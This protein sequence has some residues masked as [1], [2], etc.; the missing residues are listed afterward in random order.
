MARKKKNQNKKKRK[1]GV[2]APQKSKKR[3]TTNAQSQPQFGA[4]VA[5]SRRVVTRAPDISRSKNGE[6]TRV[7][8]SELID[9][10]AG[11]ILFS[12]LPYAL[13]PNSFPWLSAMAVDW[14]QYRFHSVTMRY[15]TR[16]PTSATG[17]V[18]MAC[19]YDPGEALPLEEKTL[20]AYAG[21]VSDVTWSDL[22][23]TLDV[24]AMFPTGPRK[25]IRNAASF[26]PYQDDRLTYAGTVVVGTVGQADGSAIGKLWVDYDVELFVPQS[27]SAL[28]APSNSGNTAIFSRVAN[29][30]LLQGVETTYDFDQGLVDL[31]PNLLSSIPVVLEAGGVLQFNQVGVF[32]AHV[33]TILRIS[34]GETLSWAVLLQVA[35]LGGVYVPLPFGGSTLCREEIDV[36]DGEMQLSATGL[37]EVQSIGTTF[38][39]RF[40]ASTVQGTAVLTIVSPFTR[41]TICGA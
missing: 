38:R 13:N 2:A 10:V 14:D 27:N 20:S 19:E 32:K 34:A 4:P 22:F 21:C 26:I 40:D 36:A 25:F 24:G 35:P 3:R 39:V 5:L 6:S 31:Y 37:I 30:I 1:A 9:T 28:G 18:Y 23:L 12:V 8:H 16:S 29:Q 7:R 41:L 11:S 33:E 15:V 17:S